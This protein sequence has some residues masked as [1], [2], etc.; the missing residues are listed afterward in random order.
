MKCLFAFVLLTLAL[1]G[2]V[3]AIQVTTE[4]AKACDGCG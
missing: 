4:P 1:A 3:A 2:G